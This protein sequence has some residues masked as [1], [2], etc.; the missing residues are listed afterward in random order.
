MYI[1]I[2]K[3]IQQDPQKYIPLEGQDDLS[4]QKLTNRDIEYNPFCC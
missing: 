1:Y 4:N 3:I 2:E